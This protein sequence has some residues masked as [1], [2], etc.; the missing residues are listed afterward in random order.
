MSFQVKF[1]VHEN[2]RQHFFGDHDT[3]A[4]NT[5]VA[6]STNFHQ[7]QACQYQLFA[8]L[9]NSSTLCNTY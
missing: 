5:G 8:D 6:L 2:E 7:F 1:Q 9:L 4:N 3:N